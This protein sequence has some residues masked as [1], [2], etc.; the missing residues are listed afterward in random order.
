MKM[1]RIKTENTVTQI[2]QKEPKEPTN[3]LG[4]G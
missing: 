1:I 3:N 2:K 4:C